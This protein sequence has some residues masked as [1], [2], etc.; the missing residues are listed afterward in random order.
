MLLLAQLWGENST[1][2]RVHGW[3]TLPLSSSAIS[4]VGSGAQQGALWV[5]GYTVIPGIL[6]LGT[7]NHWRSGGSACVRI[8][9]GPKAPAKFLFLF[10]DALANS[11]WLHYRLF[12]NQWWGAARGSYQLA[13]AHVPSRQNVVK[14][15]PVEGKAVEVGFA[16]LLLCIRL[17]WQ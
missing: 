4:S 13:Q 17:G 9:V 14:G 15:S 12:P 7:W 5:D 3:F 11:T 16:E 1:M 10:P 6:H 2:Q 8:C